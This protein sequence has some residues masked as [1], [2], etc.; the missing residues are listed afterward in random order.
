MVREYVRAINY[1]TGLSTHIAIADGETLVYSASYDSGAPVAVL[2]YQNP[3][4]G[5][6]TT[7]VSTT[8]T[9][10]GDNVSSSYTSSLGYTAIFRY[11]V[12]GTP[13]SSVYVTLDIEEASGG[14]G[15]WDES[16]V[17][18]LPGTTSPALTDEVIVYTDPGGS[19]V[20]KTSSIANVLAA[21]GLS[22]ASETLTVA[23]KLI[24]SAAASGTALLVNTAAA[25]TANLLDLQ[26]NGTSR[27]IV[28]STGYTGIGTSPTNFLDV[29]AGSLATTVQ[30]L[31]ITGT[32][33]STD[34]SQYGGSIE[35][36]SAGS[37][38]AGTRAGL[39][40]QILA[41]ATGSAY[42]VGLLAQNNVVGTGTGA[43]N[44]GT[45]NAGVRGF[46]NGSGSG[47]GVGVIGVASNATARGFGLVGDSKG[48]GTV[49]V[50][51]LGYVEAGT[52]R[53]GGIF[54]LGT[55]VGLATSAALIADNMAVS[56]AIFIARDN[57]T[58]VFT[59]ADGGNLVATGK[60]TTYNSVTTAGYGVPVVVAQGRADAQ[61]A[62]VASIC[63]YTVGASD[64]TFEVAGNVNVTTSTTHSFSVDCT[65]TDETNTAR[66][67]V[68]IVCRNGGATVNLITNTTGAGPY[69]GV[70]TMIRAKAAT[71]I[72]L[73]TSSGGTYTTVTYN[74]EG[75]I[76]QLA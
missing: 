21:A 52:V 8:F 53:I 74:C 32:L 14:S 16:D 35:I 56:A 42:T 7:L 30:A 38:S 50:G 59:I 44:D 55:I 66:T 37:G 73:R 13:G 58:A 71:A 4:T 43:L 11:R 72:T 3:T 20:L 19:P 54:A 34:A 70:A 61:T 36:T 69:A 68:L 29:V 47:D 39:Y 40:A 33:S 2:E 25:S 41:G 75:V 17:D 45:L 9:G 23:K 18:A 57:G 63:T 62:T 10:S 26:L 67:F 1:T 46:V 22:Y 48:A 49:G 64:G 5:A 65:Y 76:K 51:V 31:K 15:S 6:W 60:F 28:L 24:V 12:D 27:L